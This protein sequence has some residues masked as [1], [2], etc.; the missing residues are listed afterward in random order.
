MTLLAP[1]ALLGLVALPV[2]YALYMREDAPD[3][4]AVPTLRFWSEAT[5]ER[6]RRFRAKRPPLTWL[7]LAQMLIALIL[8]GALARPLLNVGFLSPR[9]ARSNSLSSLTA[10]R[11]WARR[12]SPRRA[13][14]RRKTARVN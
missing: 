6:G 10:A 7:M 11:A 2:I 9:A 5:S 8:V 14:R 1:L 3:T 12:T 13:L 4:F